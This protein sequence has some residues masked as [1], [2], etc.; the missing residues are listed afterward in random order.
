MREILTDLVAEQ[1]GLD[2]FLQKIAPR[3]WT[4]PTGAKGWSIHDLVSHLA[5]IEELAAQAVID[6]LDPNVMVAEAGSLNAL[7]KEGVDRGKSMRPQDVIEWWRGARAQTM[8][9]LWNKEPG[10]RMHWFGGDVSAKM[11]ATYR[12]M[13]TWAH[14][15]D[16]W[17]LY[18][19]EETIIETPRLQHIAFLGHHLL[20]VVFAQ[21]GEEYEP[22]RLEVMGPGYAKWVFGPEDADKIKGPAID[23]C[24][25]VVRRAELKDLPD[26]ETFGPAAERAIKRAAAYIEQL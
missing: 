5:S 9:A 23:W 26:L 11:M 3:L 7:V 20:E 21:A 12:I 19:D 8:D 15:L 17:D 1:Q 6:G 25:L 13:E 10:D 16:V 14:G 4:Q 18:G 2:Q 24:R 22:V